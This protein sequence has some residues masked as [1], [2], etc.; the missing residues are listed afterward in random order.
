MIKLEDIFK[1][2][3]A[4]GNISFI[5]NLNS[6][7][8]VYI[9]YALTELLQSDIELSADA[10]LSMLYADD[11]PDLKKSLADLLNGS[12]R[13]CAQFRIKINNAE[14]WLRLT[15]FLIINADEKIIAGNIFDITAEVHNQYAI[16]KYANK[17][18]SM[19][20]ILSHD[21][22][23]P[24]EIA[25]MITSS[26]GQNTADSYIINQSKNLSK[27]IKQSLDLVNDLIQREETESINVELVKRRI[28]ISAKLKEYIDEFSQ[29]EEATQ[30]EVTF[31]SSPQDIYLHLDEAKFMQVL[32][33]LMS[34]ALKFTPHGETISLS[35]KDM[36]DR[37]LFIFSDTG[38]GIP[39]K[40][41]AALFEKFTPARRKGLNGEPTVGLGLSIV[42]TVLE[43]HEGTIQV[44]SEEGQGTTFYFEI[45]KSN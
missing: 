20:S 1:K 13:G 33:N 22:R 14:R 10:I 9:D 37:V 28:N 44:E 21:L 38:I 19:L 17:K 41:H 43:W 45:P 16:H 27:I 29:S 12:F 5:Y 2:N 32:N 15:P 36:D 4:I 11:I 6:N 24:L 18:N 26:L 42:K 8:F 7:Q 23:G 30:K 39:E 25:R 34:N 40:F 31:S 3:A 35:V